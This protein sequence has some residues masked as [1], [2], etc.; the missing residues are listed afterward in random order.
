MVTIETFVSSTFEKLHSVC[1]VW[2]CY[3]NLVHYDGFGYKVISSYFS[4]CP[5]VVRYQHGKYQ[6]RYSMCCLG[7]W[8]FETVLLWITELWAII[9]ACDCAYNA[10]WCVQCPRDPWRHR[11]RDPPV[12]CFSLH[13]LFIYNLALMHCHL[14]VVVVITFVVLVVKCL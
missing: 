13:K 9:A 5:D 1:P 10:V 3:S 2:K 8:C 7:R 11:R 14:L 12:S 6:I 4:E